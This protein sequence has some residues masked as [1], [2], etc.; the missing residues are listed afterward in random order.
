MGESDLEVVANLGD[1]WFSWDVRSC[2]VSEQV[3]TT[4][5]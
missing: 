3:D 4:L 1:S 5:A 2:M